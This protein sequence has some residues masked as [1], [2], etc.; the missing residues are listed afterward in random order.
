MSL[1][2]LSNIYVANVRTIDIIMNMENKKEKRI[3]IR[4]SEKEEEYLKKQAEKCGLGVS[5]Y[6]RQKLIY[7]PGRPG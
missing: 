2:E 1:L 6:I 5:A 3:Y 4:V 7:Q